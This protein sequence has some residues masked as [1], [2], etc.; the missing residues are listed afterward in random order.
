MEELL[1]SLGINKSGTYSE[2]GCY[3]IDLLGGYDEYDNI[4]R[5]LDKAVNDEEIEYDDDSALSNNEHA[6]YIQYK[7]ETED[8]EYTILLKGNLDT[9]ECQIVVNKY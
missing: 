2:D 1:K 9:N 7:K 4:R 6:V 3:V 8:G 5:I